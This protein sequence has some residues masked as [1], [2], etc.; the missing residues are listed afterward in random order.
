MI[1]EKDPIKEAAD[2]LSKGAKNVKDTFNEGRHRTAAEIEHDKR[3]VAGDEMKPSEKIGSAV[4]EAKHRA[5]A[6]YDAGKREVRDK[7]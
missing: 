6:E 5:Q 3:D 7:T 1:V 2:E 4:N